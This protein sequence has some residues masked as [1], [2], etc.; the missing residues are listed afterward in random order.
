[1]VRDSL[2]QLR[3]G[4]LCLAMCICLTGAAPTVLATPGDAA[5]DDRLVDLNTA[6]VEELTALPGIG[7][8]T[9]KRI[10]EFREQ[11]GPFRRIED[12]LKV[13]G[14]GE[15]SFQKLRASITVSETK[16]G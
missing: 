3:V 15:K 5:N 10:V 8:V 12:L 6:S 16:K 11:N 4:A 7:E 14:I 9:A 1:M 2:R 13:K